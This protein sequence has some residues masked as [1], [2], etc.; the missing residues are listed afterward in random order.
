[1]NYKK[2][3][4]KKEN[5]DFVLI[6]FVFLVAFVF[7]GLNV[8]LLLPLVIIIIVYVIAQIAHE[9]GHYLSHWLN[10]RNPRI[11]YNKLKL[12]IQVSA[13]DTKESP[14]TF[15]ELT[16]ASLFGVLAGAIVIDIYFYLSHNLFN[17]AI[18]NVFYIY[19]SRF[20]IMDIREYLR[21]IFISLEHNKKGENE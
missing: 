6:F 12:P 7:S 2:E 8:S 9:Y 18:I 20:D 3:I 10:N 17:T 11:Y 21:N 19:A 16:R 15:G 4:L 14:F 13:F 5:K 1:M